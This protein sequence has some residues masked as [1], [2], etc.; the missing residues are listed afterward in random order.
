M[1]RSGGMG[2]G[3]ERQLAAD[4]GTPWVGVHVLTEF[5]FCPRAGVIAFEEQRDDPGEDLDR[6]PRLDYLPDFEVRLI[7]AALQKTCAGFWNLLTWTLPAVLV[8][9]VVGLFVDRWI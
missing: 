9:W 5:M 1:N 3:I 6:A 8:V 2:S 7:E 4:N